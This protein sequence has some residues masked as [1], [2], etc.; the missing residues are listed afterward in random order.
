GSLYGRNRS[1]AMECLAKEFA[2]L[3]C[4]CI[5]RG[6]K[7][8]RKRSDGLRRKSQID[9]HQASEAFSQQARTGD[10]N[11]GNR[12]LR[13][14]QC[15]AQSSATAAAGRSSNALFERVVELFAGGLHGGRHTEERGSHNAKRQG[16]KQ[17]RRVHA[18]FHESR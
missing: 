1:Y 12:H 16:E 17:N 18:R 8:N 9:L 7:N 3:F 11:Q 14:D 13:N 10:E 2:L 4:Y 6:R 15:T 5:T